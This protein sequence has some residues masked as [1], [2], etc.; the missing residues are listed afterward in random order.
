V[1]GAARARPQNRRPVESD[2]APTR[3]P[4][5]QARTRQHPSQERPRRLQAALG[6]AGFAI[7]GLLPF[8][9]AYRLG[10]WV[11]RAAYRLGDKNTAITRVNLG[12]C[13]PELDGAER[14]RLARESLMSAGRVACELPGIWAGS[15]ERTLS[16]LREVEGRELV[17]EAVAAGRGVLL[18]SPHLGSWELSGLYVSTLGP[19]TSMYRPPRVQGMDAFYRAKRTRFGAELVPADGSGV[20]AVIAALRQ[21]GIVGMLPDQDPGFGS[22][23]FVPYFGVLANTSPLVPKL[24]RKTGALG[25][26]CITLRLPDARG[27][28]L[29]LRPIQEDLLVDDEVEATTA[30]N[31]EVERLVREAPEQYLWSYKRFKIRPPGGERFYDHI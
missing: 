21:G 17:E 29:R 22:G 23:V 10:G 1:L 7:G 3:A 2:E 27:F 24:L 11:G 14:E 8:G 25:L 19:T 5:R 6:R 31:R 30:M 12:L 9:A 16:L 13:L 15:R 4:R 28:H 26:S 18:I 20:R